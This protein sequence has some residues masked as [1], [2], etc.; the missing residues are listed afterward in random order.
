MQEGFLMTESDLPLLL[1][2]DELAALLRTTRKVIYDK[3]AKGLLPGV[4]R[5]DRRLLFRR[6][7][8]LEWLRES[9]VASQFDRETK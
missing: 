6:D 2:A 3:A 7:R 9:S 8:V 1:T 5:F 4:T